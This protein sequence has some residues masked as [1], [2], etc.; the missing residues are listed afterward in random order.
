MSRKKKFTLENLLV[1][2][3]AAEGKCI[4]RYQDKVIFIP[5]VVP[6]DVVNVFVLK[7]KKDWA[8][9]KVTSFV[10]YSEKRVT[11]FCKH[12][13]GCGGCK[14]QMMPYQMQLQ[15]KEQQV[16]DQLHRIGHLTIDQ[17]LPIRGCDAISHYRNKLEFTFSNR[18][19]LNA[20]ELAAGLPFEKNVV[21]F[22]APGFFDKVIDIEE[23]HLQVEPANAIRNFLRQLASEQGLSFYDIKQHNG[24]LRNL[25]VRTTTLGETMINLVIAEDNQEVAESL[26]EAVNTAFPTL[27]SLHYTFNTKLNDSIYD[28]DVV[29]YKG[30]GWIEERLGKFRYKISPKSFFQT[31]S[32]QA[33]VLYSIVRDFAECKGHEVLYDLYCGT[34]S[35]GIFLSDRVARIVG[36]DTVEE[37]IADA[38]EN[39]ALNQLT[40]TSFA[41]G[42]VIKICNTAFFERHGDPDIIVIDPPR[43]GCH[44]QLLDK[45][46]ELRAPRI[47]YVSCNPATQARD[48]AKLAQSYS[49]TRSQAVD[50]FPQT[51]H[52]E[53]VVQLDL[54]PA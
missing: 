23:C 29:C 19:Y 11:P 2:D 44:D 45:L 9:A 3:Y 26:M 38:R 41:A 17:Y 42:D 34:G 7:N 14:W 31:N 51:H 40:N 15:F 35:I 32:K 20:T 12:F 1:V 21:G 6:G 18:Q 43:A 49:F 54:K 33:E 28:L 10:S 30:K 39:A 50:M 5:G 48:L 4:A 16:K 37:A 25:I 27:T 8:E 24:L 52:V 13:D 47:I 53:N 22:H 36:V 46:L